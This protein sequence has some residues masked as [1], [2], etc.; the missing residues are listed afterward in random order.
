VEFEQTAIFHYPQLTTPE[1][2][3]GYQ[4]SGHE[5]RFMWSDIWSKFWSY[6]EL[7]HHWNIRRYI[8]NVDQNS[9]VVL[10]LVSSFSYM[11]SKSTLF[12][13]NSVHVL[14]YKL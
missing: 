12:C 5:L 4:S 10:S 13:A 7:K 8:L 2:S 11:Y 6:D 3:V 9:H 1:F 14:S